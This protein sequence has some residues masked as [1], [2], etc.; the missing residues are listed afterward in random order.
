MSALDA[1]IADHERRGYRLEMIMP[2]DAPRIAVV[3]NGEER[4]LLTATQQGVRTE[5]FAGHGDLI[6]PEGR[7]EFVLTRASSVA[8]AQGRAGMH[9]RDLIPGHLGGRFIA[10]HIRIADG[11][12]VADYVHHHRVRFQMIFVRKGWV[13]VVYEDQGPPFDMREGDCVLQ[14]PGIRHRVLESSAGLEVIEV[15]C[16]AEHETFRDHVLELPTPTL[17]PGRKFAGQHF[18]RH[19]AADAPWDE[20]A[21]LT[22]QDTGIGRAIGGLA[23]VRVLRM[24][25]PLEHAHDGEF[26]FLFVLKG[27]AILDGPPL[28]RH[29]LD[30][31]DACTLPAST[32]YTLTPL[33]SCEVLEVALPAR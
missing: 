16:P 14:P 8:W 26:L 13:R 9:Y 19:I 18:V 30:G 11:G 6:V 10:S 15:S 7:Q 4:L 5:P 31:D 20:A 32:R 12:P 23:G 24:T 22:C 33:G 17:D 28:G 29:Q 3:T 21:G 1:A 2:A 27:A 25:R